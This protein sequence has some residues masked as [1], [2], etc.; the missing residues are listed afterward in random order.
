MK[1]K[2]VYAPLVTRAR[3]EQKQSLITPKTRAAFFPRIIREFDDVDEPMVYV[4][5]N[6]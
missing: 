6:L 4:K 2:L 5:S 3:D 1:A